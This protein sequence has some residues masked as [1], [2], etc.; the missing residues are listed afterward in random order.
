[1]AVG[2]ALGLAGFDLAAGRFMLSTR[3]A[4]LSPWTSS[5]L[6]IRLPLASLSFAGFKTGQGS[7]ATR[8]WT[9]PTSSDFF[10]GGMTLCP[11]RDHA[12]CPLRCSL[13]EG[14]L[15]V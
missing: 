1:M 4:A 6:E 3:Q 8:V 12:R 9:A 10:P 7:A 15:E 11:E 13:S 5:A 14:F 2:P